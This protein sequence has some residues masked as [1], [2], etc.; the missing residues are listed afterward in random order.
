MRSFRGRWA[1]SMIRGV[2]TASSRFGGG[3]S[4]LGLGFM[5]PRLPRLVLFTGGPSCSLCEVAKAD[6]AAVRATTPFHLSFYD[7]RRPPNPNYDPS[8]IEESDRTVWRRLYQV[9]LVS[10]QFQ[11][12]A[13]RATVRHPGPAP[14]GVIIIRGAEREDG[15]GGREDHEA[16]DRQGEASGA[17]GQVDGGAQPGGEHQLGQCS[18]GCR[19]GRRS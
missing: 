18:L 3:S 8:T 7:I 19:G 15:G 10:V 9:R 17:G 4:R 16:P 13:D 11:V 14:R 1:L 2:L 12:G 5:P 6:L